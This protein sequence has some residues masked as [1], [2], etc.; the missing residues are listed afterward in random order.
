[1]VIILLP[2]PFVETNEFLLVRATVTRIHSIVTNTVSPAPLRLSLCLSPL[3][4]R[5]PFTYTFLYTHTHTDKYIYIYISSPPSHR[6]SLSCNKH[7]LLGFQTVN[8]SHEYSYQIFSISLSPIL[9]DLS[10]W[11]PY[12][13]QNNREE[14]STLLFEEV[15]FDLEYTTMERPCKFVFYISLK[16]L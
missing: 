8:A 14:R 16:L 9:F 13:V 2:I 3:S 11:I 15:N 6:F 10:Y 5:F 1:M 7:R 12:I 4:L